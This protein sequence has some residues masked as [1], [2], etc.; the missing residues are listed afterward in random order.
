MCHSGEIGLLN[1]VQEG[2]LFTNLHDKS[3]YDPRFR[4][5]VPRVSDVCGAEDNV[6]IQTHQPTSGKSWRGKL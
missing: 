3:R 4:D 6:Q 2:V 1:V 5:C